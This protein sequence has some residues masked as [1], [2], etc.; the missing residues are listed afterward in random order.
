[1][2]AESMA[3]GYPVR[4][5]VEYP[6][7]VSRWMFL[8]RWI[9]AIPQLFIANLLGQ[10]AQLLAFFAF[11]TVLFTRRYPKG[12]FTL[13]VGCLRWQ[14]NVYAYVLFHD[15]PYPPFSFDADRYPH[16]AFEVPHRE[17]FNRWLPLVKWLL[18]VPHY[19][20]V[21]VLG[22][23]AIP[24]W[25]FGVIALLVTG[26]FPRGAFDFLAGVGR[27][28]AR[29]NAYVYLMVDEYPPFSLKA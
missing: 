29:V 20:V 19:I 27:W 1:M 4:F 3:V 6:E 25:L 15:A 2:A 8:V 17:E 24:V 13:A 21:F 28:G 7:G 14:Y 22:A 23:V 5:D 10:L 18:A 11:F 12:M 9:L 16:L 26:T